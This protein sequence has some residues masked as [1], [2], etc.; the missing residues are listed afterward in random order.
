MPSSISHEDWLA[1][2]RV[3]QAALEEDAPLPDRPAL[4]RLACRLAKSARKK[5][6]ALPPSPEAAEQRALRSAHDRADAKTHDRALLA[7]TGMQRIHFTGVETAGQGG[8][9]RGHSRSCHICGAAFR[10]IDALYHRLCPPCAVEN[11]MRREQSVDLSGRIA[12][13]TGGRIKIGQATALRLLRQGARV[14]V[15]T[16]F[17]HDA[18]HRFAAEPD[19]SQWSAR[20]EIHGLDFLDPRSIL[21]FADYLEKTLPGLDILINNAAQTVKRPD[22]FHAPARA[23]VHQPLP[24][25][26]AA[27][28]VNS[29]SLLNSAPLPQSPDQN[30]AGSPIADTIWAGT[31]TGIGDSLAASPSNPPAASAAPL[32]WPGKLDRYGLPEDFRNEN[33]WTLRAHEVPPGELLEVLL[34]NAAAPAFLVSTLKPL[35]LRS[36]WPDR[37]IVNAT[38]TDGRFGV[39]SKPSEHPHINMGKAALN[40]LTCTAAA[41]YAADRIF[42]NSVDTGW[43][44]DESGHHTREARAAAGWTPPLD[45]ADAA[46]RLCAPIHDGLTGQPYSGLLLRHYHPAAW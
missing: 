35:L 13:V 17:P 6:R 14:L 41:D 45:M 3:L 27:L 15:T 9:I 23:R 42:M 26:A 1:A 7:G 4:E 11:R 28:L 34:V 21:T 44:S 37:F 32:A 22:E 8:R 39:P 19:F 38:G 46:A 30:T 16:R 36:P 33:S 25:G 12:L 24:P 29:G 2:L 5:R 43:V 18:A 10:E 20:L 31:A 40:M